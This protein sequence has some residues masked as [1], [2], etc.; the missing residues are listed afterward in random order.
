MSLAQVSPAPVFTLF[1][2]SDFIIHFMLLLWEA[3]EQEGNLGVLCGLGT[4][5]D[6]HLEGFSFSNFN[7]PWS[8]VLRFRLCPLTEFCF[9]INITMCREW[10]LKQAVQLLPL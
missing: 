10:F 1:W 4:T 3:G 8:L 6:S 9:L 5:T 7:F 2:T